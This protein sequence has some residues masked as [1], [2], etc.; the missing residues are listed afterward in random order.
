M[1]KFIQI[2]PFAFFIGLISCFNV[3][4]YS[5]VPAISFVDLKFIDARTTDSLILTFDF[6]DENGD[7]GL[8]SDDDVCIPYHPF[9][10]VV[11]SSM[12][13]IV[14]LSGENYRLPFFTIPVS[15]VDIDEEN[16][17]LILYRCVS[18]YS[19]EIM[20]HS[21][22][23]DNR[24]L[25][26]C[27]DYEIIGEDTVYVVRNEYHF[28]F[29]LNFQRKKNGAYENIDFKRIFNTTD[30]TVGNFNSRIP[31]FDSQAKSGTI[32]YSINS[33]AFKGAFLDDSIRISF[34]I[35]D[36]TLNQSNTVYSPDFLLRD[37]TVNK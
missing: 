25:Y 13:K 26:N 16:D 37:I 20:I 1:N 27:E 9:S 19:T 10:V 17:R 12:R 2:F 21:K 14:T 33:L 18:D 31:V 28:N 24:P 34:Y 29:F 15:V 36:R 30:C 5:D 35:F 11:D 4:E 23:T 7:I 3:P 6:T 22:K 32:T 8:I